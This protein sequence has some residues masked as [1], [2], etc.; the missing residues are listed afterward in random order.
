MLHV[1]QVSNQ[2]RRLAEIVGVL[3]RYGL[4]E[5]F[6]RITLPSIR[7]LLQTPEQQAIA[8]KPFSEC[9]LRYQLEQSFTFLTTISYCLSVLTVFLT[10]GGRQYTTLK[11]S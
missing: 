5:G 9:G 11:L 6:K 10:V 1:T 3:S 8:D 7:D 4:A 2:A